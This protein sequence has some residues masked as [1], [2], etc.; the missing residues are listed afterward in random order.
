MRSLDCDGFVCFVLDEA[1]NLLALGAG[2]SSL[3]RLDETS[4]YALKG[5]RKWSTLIESRDITGTAGCIS[6]W[7]AS[8]TWDIVSILSSTDAISITCEIC[9]YLTR[10]SS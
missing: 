7:S 2:C 10:G 4:G 6:D 3:G 9:T 1:L 5:E 8:S